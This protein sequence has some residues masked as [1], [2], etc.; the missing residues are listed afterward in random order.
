MLTIIELLHRGEGHFL[1]L[2]LVHPSN[3]AA[4]IIIIH[5]HLYILHMKLAGMFILR[6]MGDF[7]EFLFESI[8]VLGQPIRF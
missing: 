3:I 4:K 1:F 8:E 2:V 7:Q 5:I 6:C